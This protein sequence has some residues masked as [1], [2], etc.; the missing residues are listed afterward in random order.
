MHITYMNFLRK[1]FKYTYKN[2]VSVIIGINI[3][4][5]ILKTLFIELNFYLGLIPAFIIARGMYWQVFTYQFIH[6]DVFHLLFNML[7]LFFFGIPTERTIGS[8]EF[9]LYYLFV[10]TLSGILSFAVYT[11]FGA[12]T[13][14]LI[15]ASGAVFGVLLLYAVMFPKSV[16]YIWGILP[17]PAPILIIGYAVLELLSMFSLNDGIAHLTHFTG[18]IAGWFYIAVR[19]GINPLKVWNSGRH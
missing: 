10:G 9:V 6:G 19:L 1:P 4:V 11:A 3:A 14:N 13:I 8:K 5:F 18:L 16:I 17:V 15:G 7:A 2:A 12:Y